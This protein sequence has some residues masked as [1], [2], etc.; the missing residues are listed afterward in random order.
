MSDRSNDSDE[1]EV[2]KAEDDESESD[3]ESD[4]EFS[5]P[6][7]FVDDITDEG[8]I[9]VGIFNE[10]L[11]S[12][13]AFFVSWTELLADLLKDRPVEDTSLNTVIVVDNA[14]KIGPERMG[15][16]KS[17]LNKVFGKFGKI[18]TEFYPVNENGLFKG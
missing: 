11:T 4:H 2:V 17:V 1:E 15:K 9:E 8:K 12:L 18:K 7:G 10:V 14:P 13:L 6:E 3:E 5:D 16:L